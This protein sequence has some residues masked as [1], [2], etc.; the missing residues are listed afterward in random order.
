MFSIDVN[1]EN[2]QTEVLEKSRTVPVLVDFWAEWC[3]PC[4][5]LKPMLESL[6]NEYAGQFILAKI[7]TDTN[8]Q[9]AANFQVRSIPSVKAIFDGKIINEFS[10]AL[11][12][13]DIR[14]FLEQILP[15]ES[16]LLRQDAITKRDAGQVEAAMNLLDKAIEIDAENVN[17]HLDKAEIY[18]SQNNFDAAESILKNLPRSAQDADTRIEEL[19]TKIKIASRLKELPDKASLMRA[20]QKNPAELQLKLD[21]ANVLIAEQNYAEALELLLET[22]RIDRKFSDEIARKTVL[23]IFTLLD[24]T[25][26]LVRESRRKLASLIN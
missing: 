8:Q 23:E 21:L 11:S 22:I 7:N 12:E 4:K 19:N 2:F 14:H 25:S 6:A 13:K 24:P 1:E 9:L 17:A 10:G 5:I 26:P 3:Q 15:N 20:I 16:E 18:V